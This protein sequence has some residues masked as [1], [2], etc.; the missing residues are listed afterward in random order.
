MTARWMLIWMLRLTGGAMLTALAFVFCPFE[1]MASI[2]QR[3][4]MGELAY[5]PLLSYLTRTLA[6]MYASMGVIVLF[7]SF[8]IDRY[9]PLIRCVGVLAILGGLGVTALDAGLRLPV[10]WTALEGPLTVLLGVVL[11]I[12]ARASHGD[13]IPRAT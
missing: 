2:H 13:S 8:D 1:W 6:A 7:V 11:L 9:R 12:L 5:T 10:F 3:I 4:G